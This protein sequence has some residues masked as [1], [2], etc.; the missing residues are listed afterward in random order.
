M[1]CYIT[2][3]AHL[4]RHN[5]MANTPQDIYYDLLQMKYKMAD[6]DD[7]HH[8]TFDRE[9][10]CRLCKLKGKEETPFHLAAECLGA[11]AT[12]RELLGSYSFDNCELIW[13][14]M[15]LLKFFKHFNLENK[16]NSL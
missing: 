9:V 15:S 4:R 12:R 8:G 14:P 6:P 7:D 10:T 16:T 1:I 2:G 11:W 5:K 13:D 3:H